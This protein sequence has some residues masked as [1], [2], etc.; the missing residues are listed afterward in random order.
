MKKI[1]FISFILISLNGCEKNYLKQGNNSL[2]PMPIYPTDCNNDNN[3]CTNENFN[4]DI[5]IS[6]GF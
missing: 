6:S 4:S 5:T 3:I 2:V 1:F